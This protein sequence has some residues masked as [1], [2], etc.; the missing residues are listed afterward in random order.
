MELENNFSL[1]VQPGWHIFA[2]DNKN[3]KTFLWEKLLYIEND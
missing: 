1:T 3:Y 2:V